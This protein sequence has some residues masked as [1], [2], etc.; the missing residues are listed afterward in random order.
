MQQFL[1]EKLTRFNS[2]FHFALLIECEIK[3]I[4]RKKLWAVFACHHNL[5]AP[6]KI[7]QYYDQANVALDC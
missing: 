2:T 6:C 5:M 3:H 1:P 7:I 4:V